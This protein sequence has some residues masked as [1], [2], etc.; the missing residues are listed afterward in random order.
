VKTKE[1]LVDEISALL[2][3]V[4]PPMS[5]GSTEPR[6]IFELIN[7]VLGLGLHSE[8]LSKPELARSIVE[9]AGR[10][11]PATAESS[12]GTVTA[13]GLAEVLAAVRFFSGYRTDDTDDSE[14]GFSARDRDPS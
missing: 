2:G 4:T 9:S 5:T 11:W 13:V 6:R 3:V 7:E 1:K 8:Q 12:G 10:T 14:G